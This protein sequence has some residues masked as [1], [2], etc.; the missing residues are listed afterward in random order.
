MTPDGRAGGAIEAVPLNYLHMV[1]AILRIEHVCLYGP[2]PLIFRCYSPYAL[3][4][5]CKAWRCAGAV[6]FFWV[7]QA[8]RACGI[9]LCLAHGRGPVAQVSGVL[10]WSEWWLQMQQW[11]FPT[12]NCILPLCFVVLTNAQIPCDV[13]SLMATSRAAFGLWGELHAVNN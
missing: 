1:M 7:V 4:F 13:F 8:P 3:C 12:F 2:S 9:W 10:K 6:V 11:F 5:M